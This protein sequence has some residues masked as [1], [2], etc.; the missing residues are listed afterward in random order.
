METPGRGRRYSMY[1]VSHYSLPVEVHKGRSMV[2]WALVNGEETGCVR[3]NCIGY[4]HTVDLMGAAAVSGWS[5]NI[6]LVVEHGIVEA[7]FC[8]QMGELGGCDCLV[9]IQE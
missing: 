5:W 7:Q 6:S 8:E 1:W 2:A 9:G 4:H 3:C